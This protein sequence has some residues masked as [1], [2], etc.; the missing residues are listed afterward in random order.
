M[1][2]KDNLI[3][4]PHK[5]GT[6]RVNSTRNIMLLIELLLADSGEVGISELSIRSRIPKSTVQR[7][8]SAMEAYGWVYKNDLT[9]GYRIGYKLLGQS[10]GWSMRLNLITQSQPILNELSQKTGMTA[11]LCTLDGYSGICLAYAYPNDKHDVPIT[12]N[13]L[14]DLHSSAEG[15]ALLA[16]APAPLVNYTLYSDMRSFTPN[17]VTDPQR[18]QEELDKIRA[19]GY[20]MSTGEIV[21]RVTSIAAP[22]L[23]PNGSAAAVISLLADK[24][25]VM[26]RVD[27]L[28]DI[29]LAA[30]RKLAENMKNV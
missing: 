28:K 14:F 9:Q 5:R 18:L 19:D 1:R 30:I 3:K 26:P 7:F 13:K 2:S 25:Y 16:Y 12:Y 11:I 4:Q 29:L 15:R 24:E 23:Y 20:A 6:M 17:T 27:K 22:L 8:M 21:D 10:I